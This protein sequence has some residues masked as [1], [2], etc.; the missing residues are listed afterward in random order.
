MKKHNRT[1]SL[2]LSLSSL[3]S[4]SSSLAF[5]FPPSTCRYN[6]N[7]ALYKP[8]RICSLHIGPCSALVSHLPHSRTMRSK[9][10][11]F[12]LPDVWESVRAA[13]TGWDS[14]HLDVQL[15]CVFPLVSFVTEGNLPVSVFLVSPTLCIFL[16]LPSFTEMYW[17]SRL[18]SGFPPSC[19]GPPSVNYPSTLSWLPICILFCYHSHA[20]PASQKSRF[21]VSRPCKCWP[22]SCAW[23]TF[24]SVLGQMT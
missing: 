14:Q 5:S 2:S 20:F 1:F 23:N 22:N 18:F 4:I 13:Q 19:R 16:L 17:C 11:L 8:R 24:S 15:I 12:K 7:M 9:F 3:P 21:C 10:L 6:K